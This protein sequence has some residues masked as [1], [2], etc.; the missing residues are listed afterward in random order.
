MRTRQMANGLGEMRDIIEIPAPQPADSYPFV[1]ED[2][3]PVLC[4]AKVGEETRAPEVFADAN[5]IAYLLLRSAMAWDDA[6]LRAALGV[7]GQD[8]LA[9]PGRLSNAMARVRLAI[10]GRDERDFSDLIGQVM[11]LGRRV[12]DPWDGWPP[13]PQSL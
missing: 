11:S 6:T 13:F 12:D 1:F 4:A 9:A 2:P 10:Q 5:V 7:H 3:C 8:P